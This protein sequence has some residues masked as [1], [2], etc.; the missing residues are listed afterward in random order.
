MTTAW[1]DQ[2]KSVGGVEYL[3]QENGDFLLLEIGDKIL[4]EQSG[5]IAWSNQQKS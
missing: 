1:T 4:L 3:L 2:N 5:S